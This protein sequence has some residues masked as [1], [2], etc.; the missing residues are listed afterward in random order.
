MVTVATSFSVVPPSRVRVNFRSSSPPPMLFMLRL[1]GDGRDGDSPNRPWAVAFVVGRAHLH[2]VGLARIDRHDGRARAGD[3]LRAVRPPS[4]R[5]PRGTGRRS[6]RWQAAL[7]F[8]GAV[9]VT[10]RLVVPEP[11]TVTASG[12]S[13]G[14]S[15]SV[16]LTATAICAVSVP[17]LP[18]SAITM[19]SYPV[20]GALSW[21][22]TRPVATLVCSWPVAES[23]WK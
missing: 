10:C 21:L 19:M 11:V 22:K 5:P 12:A 8:G 17:A 7:S 1:D 2:F 14:S 18:S 9:H 20:A 6:P 3:V 23:I 4:S 16:T 13:G 15:T